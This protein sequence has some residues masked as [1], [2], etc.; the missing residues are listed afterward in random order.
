MRNPA[1]EWCDFITLAEEK[2]HEINTQTLKGYK[3]NTESSNFT[4]TGLQEK[5]NVPTKAKYIKPLLS[6]V[7]T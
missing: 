3:F 4:G 5:K 1:D 7:I 2:T 6:E